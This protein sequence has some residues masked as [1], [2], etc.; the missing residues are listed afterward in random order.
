MFNNLPDDIIKL[1]M[2]IKTEEEQK[3]NKKKMLKEL[4]GIISYAKF[5]FA[6]YCK[7][8]NLNYIDFDHHINTNKFTNEILYVYEDYKNI[9]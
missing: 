2:D 1:I 6:E 9:Y 3:D 4:N 5:N 8:H 7:E